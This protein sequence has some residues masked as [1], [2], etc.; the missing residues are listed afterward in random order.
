MRPALALHASS[1]LMKLL[2]AARI[3]R[4]DFLRSINS[5][6]RN[7]TKWS[8]DDD[9]RLHHLMCSVNSTLK[10]RMV[11]WVGDDI[12]PLSLALYADADFAGCGQSLRSTSGSHMHVQGHH[13]RFPLA[14]GS[15]RQGCVSHSTLE[16]EIVAADVTLRTTG[17]PSL[18]LWSVIAGSLPRLLF[19]DDNQGMIGVVR[20]GRN[21]TMRHLERTRGIS[22][23]SLRKHFRKEH[24]VLLYEITS[25]MAADMHTKG[26]RNPLAWQRASMLI[27]L[28]SESDL[29]TK[30]LADIVA[31]TTDVDTTTRQ[32]FQTKSNDVPNFPYTNTPVLPPAVY[33]QGMTGKIGLQ[34]VPG[35]DPIFVA[36]TPV[37]YRRAPSGSGVS[38]DCPRS[39]WILSNG[40]WRQVEDRVPRYQRSDRFDQWVE[41]A[42]FQYH[43]GYPTVGPVIVAPSHSKV[44]QS[45]VP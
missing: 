32:L 21:P 39:T 6:A 22:I 44:G 27:N 3:A 5:L 38:S 41:R 25:K 43:R 20:S 1:V 18:S 29:G 4:F 7:V 15:K 16:A 17:L 34:Q 30:L 28:L 9:M 12:S 33:R 26:F 35:V 31:P 40:V 45:G 2:Y 19:H 13:T 10:L 37:L 36:K 14:G 8:K 24:F 11:G 42:C 23:M